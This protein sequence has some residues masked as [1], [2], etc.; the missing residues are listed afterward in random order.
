MNKTHFPT[1]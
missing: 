1:R